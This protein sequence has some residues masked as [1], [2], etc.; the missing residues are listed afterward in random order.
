MVRPAAETPLI[1]VHRGSREQSRVCGCVHTLSSWE[2]T[3][4]GYRY[5][6]AVSQS[7]GLSDVLVAELMGRRFELGVGNGGV[8]GRSKEEDAVE[9]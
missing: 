4:S 3:H 6:A 1:I 5:P 7:R 9:G 8:E 2:Y